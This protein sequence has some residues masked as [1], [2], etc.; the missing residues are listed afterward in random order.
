[1]GS[2]Y[3]KLLLLF[4]Y[5]SFLLFIFIIHFQMDDYIFNIVWNTWL[6]LGKWGFLF[7]LSL[8]VNDEPE[9]V[10][11]S[12][13]RIMLIFIVYATNHVANFIYLQLRINNWTKGDAKYFNSFV[14][15][16]LRVALLLYMINDCWFYCLCSFF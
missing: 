2:H 11:L 9:L 3:L 12:W 10:I 8:D 16:F 5:Y 13:S 14:L 1:M 15:F 4:N 6:N 7:S